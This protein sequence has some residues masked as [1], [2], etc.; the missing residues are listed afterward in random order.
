MVRPPTPLGGQP[1]T[2]LRHISNIKLRERLAAPSFA[3]AG[4]NTLL[5][6]GIPFCNAKQLQLCHC[7]EGK[8]GAPDVAI[9]RYD[10]CFCCAERY[11]VP[12]DCHVALLLAMTCSEPISITR[13]YTFLRLA[14]PKG[15]PYCKKTPALLERVFVVL[16]YRAIQRTGLTTKQCWMTNQSSVTPLPPGAYP[17]KK[18]L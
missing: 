9:S 6:K 15:I 2:K 12:G 17:A 16:G 8:S 10:V 1:D 5:R 7:E 13:K 3:I 14:S 4:R 18:G 11:M